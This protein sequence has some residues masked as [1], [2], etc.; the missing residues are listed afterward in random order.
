MQ[1]IGWKGAA[2]A[3]LAA[4]MVVPAI[5]P[6]SA[7][8][9][10][11]PGPRSALVGLAGP[12]HH[13]GM[14]LERP[15]HASPVT[16]L[17]V[18]PL[19]ATLD[20]TP[21][22]TIT[23][24]DTITPT[25][26]L[27]PTATVTPT[28]TLT[29]T[30]PATNT[31]LPTATSTPQPTNTPTPRPTSTPTPRPVAVQLLTVGV[32]VLAKG[33]EQRVRNETLGTRVRLKMVVRVANAPHG[34]RVTAAWALRGAV[35]GKSYLRYQR[36]FTLHNGRTGVYDD[37]A[38]PASGFA[39]GS[40]LFVGTI[41]YHGRVQQKATVLRVSAQTTTGFQSKRVHYAHL[42]LTVPGFW[43]V[44]FQKDSKGQAATGRDTLLMFSNTRRA[45][46]SVVSVALN[47]TPSAADL[48]AFPPLVLNQVFGSVT[49]V[50]VLSYKATIDGHDVFGAEGDVSI[51]GR[52]SHAIAIVTNKK[53]QLYAFTVVNYFKQAQAS[54]IA[55]GLAAVFGS[56]LD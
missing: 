56:K 48:H 14:A 47:T 45:A 43:F 27:T 49:N 53:R 26:T 28:A 54:E 6:L 15:S 29:P 16:M 38:L 18:G 9:M 32:Y 4:A 21:T 31:P 2:T 34:V 23:P 42:R 17:G 30:P 13:V 11:A 1:R 19:A 37:V 39:A 41:T 3:L 8:A 50:K 33:H 46:V 55:A 51:G 22:A 25:A 10:A 5:T 40:Y 20:V 52:P 12:L 35:G 36:D 24:T 7:G 44:D